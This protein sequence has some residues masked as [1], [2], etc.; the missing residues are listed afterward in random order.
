MS[1]RSAERAACT[2]Q[3]PNV[4]L[5]YTDQQRRDSVGCYGAPFAA[6]PH[7]DALAASGERTALCAGAR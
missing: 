1:D 5:L 2:L 6:T 7:L 3:R 4:L